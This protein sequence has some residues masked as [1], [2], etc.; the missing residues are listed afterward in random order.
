VLLE[1]GVEWEVEKQ[2]EEPTEVFRV[3][4]RAFSFGQW[5]LAFLLHSRKLTS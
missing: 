2:A 5:Y 4:L 3:M 1:H